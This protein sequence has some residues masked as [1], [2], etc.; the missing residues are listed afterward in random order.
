MLSAVF[1]KL[2]PMVA[3]G[4]TAG[5]ICVRRSLHMSAKCNASRILR[6]PLADC[7]KFSLKQIPKP[8][9]TALSAFDF[10]CQQRKVEHENEL[11]S[12]PKSDAIGGA[13]MKPLPKDKLRIDF[14]TLDKSEIDKFTSMAIKDIMRYKAE[15]EEYEQI[16]NSTLTVRQLMDWLCGVSGRAMAM[17]IMQHDKRGATEADGRPRIK[18]PRNGYMFFSQ[19]HKRTVNRYT[20]HK[21]IAAIWHA[22]T[23][24]ERAPYKQMHEDDK[25]R[26]LA[27]KLSESASSSSGS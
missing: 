26:Y 12:V 11:K 8:P 22:M 27:E 16:M 5:S 20:K 21:E 23:E 17:K 2:C 6:M 3:S 19:I 13:A 25:K 14:A 18:R 15:L 7:D 9:N 10:Y 4:V 24:A 1:A